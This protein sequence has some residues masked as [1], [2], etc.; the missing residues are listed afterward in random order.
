MYEEE[1]ELPEGVRDLITIVL[2]C[3]VSG[4]LSLTL[5]KFMTLYVMK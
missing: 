2:A 4:W 5:I 1:P 3:I